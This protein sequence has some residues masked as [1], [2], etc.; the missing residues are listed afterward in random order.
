MYGSYYAVSGF[1]ALT[2]AQQAAQAR[3]AAAGR[4]RGAAIAAD[5]ARR[6]EAKRLAQIA[7]MMGRPAS[8]AR[9]LQAAHGFGAAGLTIDPAQTWNEWVAGAGGDNAAGKR[10]AQALQAA[11]NQLGYGPLTVDGVWGPKSGAAFKAFAA[12]QGTTTNDIYPTQD[13]IEKIALL[14][15][16]GAKPGPA[17]A[18]QY[19]LIGGQYVTTSGLKTAGLGTGLL[20][21]G[22]AAAA[23][24]LGGLVLGA[25]K[26]KAAHHSP[27]PM[28]ANRRR[29][30]R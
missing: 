22:G 18:V 14:L 17:P 12:A 1:G 5:M 7:S 21:A 25:K 27:A 6:N 11:L 16:G 29:H 20:I 23:I 10:A 19:E 9:I 15:Q 4:A 24:I 8:A 30:R 3:A 28:H 26:K 13:G 2:A